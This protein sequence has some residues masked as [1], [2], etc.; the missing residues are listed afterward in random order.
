MMC[1][2]NLRIVGFLFC[3]CNGGVVFIHLCRGINRK[4]KTGKELH[5]LLSLGSKT[6]QIYCS[7]SN[8]TG[9]FMNECERYE[10]C[11]CVC[12]LVSN[13]VQ[14]FLLRRQAARCCVS[15]RSINLC[16]L[17][18]LILCRDLPGPSCLNH[19][20][21]K[22]SETLQFGA[23]VGTDEF[24]VVD[25]GSAWR[26]T[27]YGRNCRSRKRPAKDGRMEC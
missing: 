14:S 19:V 1:S 2:C 6:K 23:G 20:Y 10:L 8:L 17:A 22:R 16:T 15:L 26:H 5:G 21:A 4:K 11:A 9:E 12:S 13:A 3:P 24:G 27:A 7:D 25:L 18:M